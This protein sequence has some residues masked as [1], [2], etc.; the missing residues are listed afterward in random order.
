MYTQIKVSSL[1]F[2]L[3][4][5]TLLSSGC[6]KDPAGDYSHL[7]KSQTVTSTTGTSYTYT[8]AY[9]SSGRQIQAQTDT[10][11]TTYTYSPGVVAVVTVLAGERFPTSY[12]TDAAG[13][14]ISDS[15]GYSYTYDSH[16]YLTS[17]SSQTAGSFDST[18]YTISGGN[19]DTTIR[20]Q[21]D[22]STSNVITAA[23]TFLSNA[24]TRDF[25]L[26]FTGQPNKNLINTQTITQVINGSI[27]TAS[28]SYSYSFDSRGR[29]IQQV[30]DNGSVSY[31]TTYVYY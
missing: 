1:L 17:L 5:V 14:A 8:Y 27:V 22:P 30:Q 29:V 20:H 6:R 26:T 4:V 12:V 13:L 25:G 18:I 11:V 23:Y 21:G 10:V 3:A 28:Y 15:R 31:T 7:I 2:I 19:T 16:G 9:D 24:D